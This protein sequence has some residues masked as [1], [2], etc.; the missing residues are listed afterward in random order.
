[1]PISYGCVRKMRAK[2]PIRFSA[3]AKTG[4]KSCGETSCRCVPSVMRNRTPVRHK[5]EQDCAIPCRNSIE[6]NGNSAPADV[7][8]AALRT[9]TVYLNCCELS[10][11]LSVSAVS[12]CSVSHG[13]NFRSALSSKHRAGGKKS[14]YIDRIIYMTF[15]S[16]CISNETAARS[17]T[18][19]SNS[20][21]EI[22]RTK[23]IRRLARIRAEMLVGCRQQK[24]LVHWGCSVQGCRNL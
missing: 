20:S 18:V 22:G 12:D 6:L 21:V 7:T 17:S 14:T 5:R 8:K 9:A 15:G 24:L 16:E 1:M 10:E 3:S 23:K 11:I 13:R 19:L 4:C 2:I